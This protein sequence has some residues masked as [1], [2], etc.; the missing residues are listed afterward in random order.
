MSGATTNV[1]QLET[2]DQK[3]FS[4][5]YSFWSHDR[6]E[7]DDEGVFQPIDTKYADQ[8]KVYNEIG[9]DILINAW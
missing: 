1:H 9:A 3:T 6:F 4:F 7:I 8:K 2:G 5:D